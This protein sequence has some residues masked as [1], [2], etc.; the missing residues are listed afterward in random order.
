MQDSWSC[1]WTR[2]YILMLQ[3]I[4][5]KWAMWH[6]PITRNL[7]STA[8]MHFN[9]YRINDYI[10]I[11]WRMFMPIIIN[12]QWDLFLPF[13]WNLLFAWEKKLQGV[14]RT[15]LNYF[16]NKTG[17]KS[18]EGCRKPINLFTMPR[19]F[20][21]NENTEKINQ[22]FYHIIDARDIWAKGGANLPTRKK[23]SSIHSFY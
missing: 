5:D 17:M 6:R 18:P 2:N 7:R 22:T 20:I 14:F 15:S 3:P 12:L 16:C 1:H 8:K 10:P 23:Y 19:G 9:R 13:F 11:K 4:A 21:L